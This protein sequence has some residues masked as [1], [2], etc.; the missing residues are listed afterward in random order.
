[1][2]KRHSRLAYRLWRDREWQDKSG[3][4]FKTLCLLSRIKLPFKTIWNSTH[5]SVTGVYT[6]TL[7]FVV[8]LATS[9]VSGKNN[10]SSRIQYVQQADTGV[11]LLE[12]S[13]DVDRVLLRCKQVERQRNHHNIAGPQNNPASDVNAQQQSAAQKSQ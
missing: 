2:E 9:W 1:M 10:D 3:Q 4:P 13:P 7:A 6:A 11:V 12:C 5:W 8:A